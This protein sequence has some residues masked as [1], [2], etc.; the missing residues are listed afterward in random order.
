[1]LASGVCA[2]DVDALDGKWEAFFPFGDFGLVAGHE[3]VGQIVAIGKAV[4]KSHQKLGLRV[5]CGT[6]RNACG[7]CESC[8]TGSDNVCDA[9]EF[10]YANGAH[11]T[12]SEYM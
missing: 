8:L 12:F 10:T 1:M 5:G 9:R 2:S 4:P 11:G 3:G 6:I 7:T